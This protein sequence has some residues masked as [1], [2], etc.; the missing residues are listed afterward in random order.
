MIAASVAGRDAPV[1]SFSLRNGFGKL[2]LQLALL[3]LIDI[4]NS[5]FRGLCTKRGTDPLPEGRASFRTTTG[6]GS[7]PRFV[8]SRFRGQKAKSVH[9]NYKRSHHYGDLTAVMLL[10]NLL[11]GSNKTVTL[12][13]WR[14]SVRTVCWIE[15]GRRFC[16]EGI[17]AR[18]NHLREVPA[19]AAG[20]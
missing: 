3:Q 8:Q 4:H 18:L 5:G 9:A 13:V 7:V 14:P 2:A 1:W 11:H 20:Q 6:L 16:F 17:H 19:A 12:K 15:R 10:K